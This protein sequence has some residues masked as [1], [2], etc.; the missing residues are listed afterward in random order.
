MKNL[1]RTLAK[2]P[3]GDLD[4]HVGVRSRKSHCGVRIMTLGKCDT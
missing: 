2:L 1:G 4:S 3:G